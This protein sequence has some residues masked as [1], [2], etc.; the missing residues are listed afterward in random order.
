M[1]VCSEDDY[2]VHKRKCSACAAIFC[3]ER[4]ELARL[5]VFC[6]K[7][8][9]LPEKKLTWQLQDDKDLPIL[10]KVLRNCNVNMH[11]L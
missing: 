10:V 11:M 6:S 2:F 1:C 9:K 5:A 4:A 3:L 7:L 8:G